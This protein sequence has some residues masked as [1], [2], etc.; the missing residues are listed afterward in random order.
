MGP[1]ETAPPPELGAEADYGSS[2][3]ATAHPAVSSDTDSQGGT[4]ESTERQPQP[5]A[6]SQE[7]DLALKN[8]V[9]AAYQGKGDSNAQPSGAAPQASASTEDPRVGQKA[10]GGPG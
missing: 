3:P 5:E 8:A 2:D 4:A 7:Q 6:G 9:E 10:S 1:E